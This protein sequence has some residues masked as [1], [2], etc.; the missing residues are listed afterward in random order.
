MKKYNI[1]L[2]SGILLGFTSCQPKVEQSTS[3]DNE[4]LLI[5]TLYVQQAAEFNALNHQAY[6][7]GK[8]RLDEILKN[9]KADRK[10]AIVVDIDETVLDNSP[11][12]AKS[13][14]EKTSYPMYWAEWCNLAMAES[15]AGALEFLNYAAEK[16]VETFYISNRKVELFDSTMAN[17]I[18]NGFPFADTTHILLRTTTS[19][20]EPRRSIVKENFEIVL[21]FGDNLGDLSHIFDN[22]STAD[23]NSMVE[24]NKAEFGNRFIVL[25][26]P[27]YGAWDA[28]MFYD[29]VVDN[30]DSVYKARLKSF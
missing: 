22:K 25:P 26:N 3:V 21:L 17:L 13:I 23:R 15:V 6:N 30:K 14:L 18:S 11:F 19:D 29:L 12:E 8:L 2:L 24:E 5:A 1:I 10:L 4:K 28:A 20:K 9:S 16:G 7:I 27:M